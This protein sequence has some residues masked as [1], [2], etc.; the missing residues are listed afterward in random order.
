[1]TDNDILYAI[2]EKM[3]HM[4]KGHR[5]IAN[6]VLENYDEA[7]F[8][9]AAKVGAAIGVSESTVVRFAIA[10]GYAGYPEYQR[11]LANALKDRLST[12]QK[13]EKVHGRSNYDE[14]YKNIIAADIDNMKSLAEEMNPLAF[15]VAVDMML[16][17][18]NVYIVGLGNNEPLAMYLYNYLNIIRKNVILVNSS[19]GQDSLEKVFRIDEKDALV[20][21]SFPK[22]SMRTLKAMELANDRNAKVISI[23]DKEH[24]PMNLYSSCNLLARADSVS[25]IESLTAPFALISALIVAIS[26]KNPEAINHN[27]SLLEQVKEDYRID[28][29]DEIEY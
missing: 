11:A 2:R 22:Y 29:R 18:E 15:E 12:M 10:M 17:A 4:S 24:S 27:L 21:I 13:L 19:S 23:T 26:V 6:Y 8:E 25:S 7:A 5:K 28:S 3:Q 20:G 14:L 16:G 1:M 9:T